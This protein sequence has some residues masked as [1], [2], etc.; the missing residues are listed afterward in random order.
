MDGFIF[1]DYISTSL[2]TVEPEGEQ[3]VKCGRK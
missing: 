1:L 2:V 3:L